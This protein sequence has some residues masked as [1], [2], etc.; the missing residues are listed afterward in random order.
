MAST[1]STATC[2]LTDLSNLLKASRVN[3]TSPGLS[4]TSST[5]FSVSSPCEFSVMA[6]SLRRA[7]RQFGHC[8]PKII[9]GLYDGFE[10]IQLHWLVEITVRVK[11]IARQNIGF[12]V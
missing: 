10:C 9:D 5:S 2:K 11:L 12:S 8:Q 6:L 1:P 3:R 7:R 4:S